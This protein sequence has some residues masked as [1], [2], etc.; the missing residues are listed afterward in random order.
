MFAFYDIRHDNLIIVKNACDRASAL[1]R[2]I[3]KYGPR[4]FCQDRLDEWKK[5]G[6]DG[7][8]ILPCGNVEEI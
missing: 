3:E 5:N 1:D 7:S 8:L 2:V 4:Y 6:V